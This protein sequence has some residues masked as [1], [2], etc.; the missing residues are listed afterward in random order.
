MVTEEMINEKCQVL[1]YF[2][3]VQHNRLRF[4]FAYVSIDERRATFVYLEISRQMR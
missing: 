2:F 3:E 4:Y 1:F